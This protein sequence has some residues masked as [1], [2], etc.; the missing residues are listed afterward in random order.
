MKKQTIILI[1][2]AFACLAATPA[3]AIVHSYTKQSVLSSG[4]WVKIQVKES[5][6]YKMTYEDLQAAGLSNPANV[7]L[8]G[9][10]GAMLSQNFQKKHID[11][12]PAVS[13]YMNKGL[14]IQ[15]RTVCP[16]TQSVLRLWLLFLERQRRRATATGY[17]RGT[18]CV[19]GCCQHHY[20]SQLSSA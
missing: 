9:Y 10:G 16:Y 4:S 18:C 5:G 14:D 19:R 12:L 6:I 13:F 20:L 17:R 3:G 7:R 15:W 8:Y 2:C 1:I 11:D